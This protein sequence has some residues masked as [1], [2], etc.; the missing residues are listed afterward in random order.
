M[1]E[2]EIVI[3]IDHN[4][5]AHIFHNADFGIV[6][7]YTDIIPELIDRVKAGFTFGIEAKKIEQN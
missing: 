4:P 1:K 3:A 7:E 6:G 5:K 2:S